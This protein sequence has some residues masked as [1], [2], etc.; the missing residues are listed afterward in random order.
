MG[1]SEFV[2][3]Y[4]TFPDQDTAKRIAEALV[5][6]RLAACAN[7]YPSMTSLYEWEGRMEVAQEVSAFI[8]LPRGNVTKAID[9]ARPLHP[10][11]VPCFLVLPVEG[12][13]DDYLAWARAQTAR[14]HP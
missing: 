14:A 1:E 5:S 7:I 13:N 10:Y 12:G 11:T 3:L 6:Q 9:V 8:K 4:A 2:F